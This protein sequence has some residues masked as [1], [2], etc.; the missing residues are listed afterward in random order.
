MQWR[1]NINMI[2]LRIAKAEKITNNEELGKYKNKNVE[3]KN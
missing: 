3:F 2:F 1:Q